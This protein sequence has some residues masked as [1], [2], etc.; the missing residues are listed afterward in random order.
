MKRAWTLCWTPQGDKSVTSK[1]DS[2]LQKRKPLRRWRASFAKGKQRSRML[3]GNGRR[4]TQAGP[5]CPDSRFPQAKGEP[6]AGARHLP[7]ARPT[8]H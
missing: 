6:M 1:G 2:Q 3:A 4:L 7:P 8:I 5:Q